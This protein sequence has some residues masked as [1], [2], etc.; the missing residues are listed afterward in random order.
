[1]P[2]TKLRG[3]IV[4]IIV[5]AK[6][7][8]GLKDAPRQALADRQIHA[9]T[10]NGSD[11]IVG[12][13]TAHAGAVQTYQSV[14]EVIA[15]I[16]APHES[17]SHRSG[18]FVIAIPPIVTQV[19]F[20]APMGVDIIGEGR[21]KSFRHVRYLERRW[22]IRIAEW[23]RHRAAWMQPLI[24]YEQ[25]PSGIRVALGERWTRYE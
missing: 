16:G 23:R 25:I 12:V 11:S 14:Q 13:E 19:E 2:Q 5:R 15:A 10:E 9:S 24:A 6:H 3:G 20:H 1:M 17:R 22:V 18:G 4:G 8:V 7:I 21:A